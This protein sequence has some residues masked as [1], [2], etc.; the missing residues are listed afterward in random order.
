[1]ITLLY[2]LFFGAIGFTLV[3]QHYRIQRLE[4]TIDG[5]LDLPGGWEK[6]TNCNGYVL[7]KRRK[8]Q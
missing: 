5:L 4:I 7:A 8:P 6:V 2:S 3:V 1:M